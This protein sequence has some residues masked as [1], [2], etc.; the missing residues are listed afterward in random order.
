MTL[1]WIDLKEEFGENERSVSRW[2]HAHANQHITN[3]IAIPLAIEA[4]NW[5]WENFEH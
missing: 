5:L 3:L 4:K 2:R 1:Q